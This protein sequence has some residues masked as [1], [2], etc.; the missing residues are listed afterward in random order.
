MKSYF[1][2]CFVLERKNLKLKEEIYL[3]TYTGDCDNISVYIQ[4]VKGV[5]IIFLLL[6]P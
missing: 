6:R 5:S 2:Y 3:C 4:T 1:E